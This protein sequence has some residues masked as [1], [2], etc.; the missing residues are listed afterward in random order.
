MS[1]LAD[2]IFLVPSMTH[3]INI[4]SVNERVME[5]TE[6]TWKENRDAGRMRI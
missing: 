6:G 1:V 2:F 5:A 3:S 4:C